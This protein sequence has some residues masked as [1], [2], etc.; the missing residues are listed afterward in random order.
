LTTLAE[1]CRVRSYLVSARNHGLRPIDAIHA[2][3][4]R[5][6]WLPTIATA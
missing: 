3:L 5:N 1:Y 2:A 4:N 6:P